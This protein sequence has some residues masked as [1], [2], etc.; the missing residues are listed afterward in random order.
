MGTTED[1]AQGTIEADWLLNDACN[2]TPPPVYLQ[3][4]SGLLRKGKKALKQRL[5]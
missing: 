5:R 3:T 1:A 2:Q 4:I